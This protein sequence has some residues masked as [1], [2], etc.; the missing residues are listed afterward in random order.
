M[1]LNSNLKYARVFQIDRSAWVANGIV[2]TAVMKGSLAEFGSASILSI[3]VSSYF[4]HHYHHH[5]H[6]E[7]YKNWLPARPRLC[8]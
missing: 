5:H 6:K 1:F 2:L 3:L 8:C 7:N 4:S